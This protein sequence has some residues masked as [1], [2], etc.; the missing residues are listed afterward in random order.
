MTPSSIFSLNVSHPPVTVVWST[1]SLNFLTVIRVLKMNC[2][3]WYLWHWQY[4]PSLNSDSSCATLHVY[5]LL[6][7]L[8]K[9]SHLSMPSNIVP[10]LTPTHNWEY[11]ICIHFMYFFVASCGW[12]FFFYYFHCF[13][14][15]T[16]CLL[17]PLQFWYKLGFTVHPLW[18]QWI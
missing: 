14:D 1:A 9:P 4:L 5:N 2:D 17:L 13:S 11:V 7:N 3:I 12:F 8:I 15:F 10:L 16:V 6:N 18:L